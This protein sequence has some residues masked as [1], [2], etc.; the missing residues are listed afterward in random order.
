MEGTPRW[1]SG[2]DPTQAFIARG[3]GSIPG[4][5]KQGVVWWWGKQKFGM[6]KKLHIPQIKMR[7]IHATYDNW[8][9][10]TPQCLNMNQLIKK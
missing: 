5:G 1:S 3:M 8:L 9:I 6:E 2:Q 7:K 10:Q 4:Q